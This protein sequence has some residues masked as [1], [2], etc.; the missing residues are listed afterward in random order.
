[1]MMMALSEP[2]TGPAEDYLKVIYDLERGSGVAATNDIAERLAIA[3]PSAS[4]MVKR[5]ADQGLLEYERYRGVRLTEAGRTAAL[6]T[7]RRHRIVESYL[8]R[9]LG[10]HPDHVH[11]EA[12]RMEHAASDDL[13]DRM[14]RA[15]GDPLVDP[16]GA[17]I[18]T[19]EECLRGSVGRDEPHTQADG[20]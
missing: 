4:G 3:P 13:I 15:I 20:G 5:L 9:A 18:P 7:L 17:P 12:E 10:Y 6:G 8:V 19:R 16:H 11:E 1:M 14:A 2:L